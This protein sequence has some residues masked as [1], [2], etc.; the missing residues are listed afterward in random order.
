MQA[1]FYKDSDIKFEDHPKYSGVKIA[2]L[3]SEKDGLTMGVSQLIIESGIEIPIHTHD[4]H[5]DSIY[6]IDG[7]GEAFINGE[8][9]VIEKGDYI[10]VPAKV[11][12]GVKNKS[13][14]PLRLFI[15]HNP[16]LF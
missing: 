6:V 16:A 10:I 2:K 3:I 4:P 13:D 14:A 9:K 7:K 5:I 12:H 1:K 8:W 15:V 11:E